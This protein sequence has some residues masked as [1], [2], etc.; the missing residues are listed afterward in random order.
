MLVER[1]LEQVY[2]YQKIQVLTITKGHLL[3][4]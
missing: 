3:V 1:M 4:L 2:L